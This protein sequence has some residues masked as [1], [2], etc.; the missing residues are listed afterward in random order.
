MGG[1]QYRFMF[2]SSLGAEEAGE[3]ERLHGIGIFVV[4][5]GCSYA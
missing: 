4:L 5:H 3:T 1:T 2:D